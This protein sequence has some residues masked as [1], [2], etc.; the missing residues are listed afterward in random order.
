MAFPT[1]PQNGDRYSNGKTTWEYSS[2]TDSWG[3]IA[4]AAANQ[5]SR[6]VTDDGEGAGNNAA[7]SVK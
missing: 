3:V 6:M 2:A 5:W 1:N 7:T 4:D